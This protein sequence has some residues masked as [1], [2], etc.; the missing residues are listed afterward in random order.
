MPRKHSTADR[1]PV[2]LA[3]LSPS[4]SPAQAKLITDADATRAAVSRLSRRLKQAR[5]PRVATVRELAEAAARLAWQSD[6]IAEWYVGTC[7]MAAFTREAEETAR[8]ERDRHLDESFEHLEAFHG[9]LIFGPDTL[10]AFEK[11]YCHP[12]DLIE[13]RLLDID[14][15]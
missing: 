14:M 11:Q 13:A 2:S 6:L 9:S 5:R 10:D 3:A 4:L 7:E 12:A 15:Q 8:A 1:R